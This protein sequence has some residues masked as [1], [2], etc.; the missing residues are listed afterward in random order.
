VNVQKRISHGMNVL[1]Y[2]TTKEWHFKNENFKNLRK[3][4]TKEDDDTF[5][6]DLSTLSPDEYMKNYILGA[7]QFCCKEDMS[8]LPRARKLNRM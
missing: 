1:T 8:T 5:F 3:R 7:R 6:T 2:Y 4:V